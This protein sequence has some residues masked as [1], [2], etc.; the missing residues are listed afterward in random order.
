MDL[1]SIAL[2]FIGTPYVYGGNNITTGLDCSA[3]ALEMLRSVGKW[4]KSD[5]S[6]QMIYDKIIVYSSAKYSFERN[7]LIFYGK[8]LTS[9]SH[10]AIS[11]GDNTVIEAGGEGREPSDKGYVRIRP[12]DYRSDLLTGIRI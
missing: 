7:A 4:D 5:A 2:L 12:M 11:M 9:I 1:V 8:S 6:A 3:F 10:I